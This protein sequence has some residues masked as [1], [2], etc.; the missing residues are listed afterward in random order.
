LAIGFV[1]LV[2]AISAGLIG[3]A[4][5]SLN[6]RSSLETVRN[7]EYAADGAV[8]G[9]LAVVRGQAGPSP[10]SCALSSGFVLD[11]TLNGIA[12]RVDWQNACGVVQSSTGTVVAQ[13]NVIFSACP[14]TG[15]PCLEDAVIVRAQVNF[16]QAA[17]LVTKTYVQS[18]SVLR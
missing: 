2:G 4:T 8:E 15:A 14:D 1:A 10:V 16:E 6:N 13:R 9:A 18:W 17:G 12:I 5:S 7:T 3:L 11:S